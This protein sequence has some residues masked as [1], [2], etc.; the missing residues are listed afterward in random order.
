VDLVV[1]SVSSKFIWSEAP[2]SRSQE[3]R[4]PSPEE[5]AKLEPMLPYWRLFPHLGTWPEESWKD[6]GH[7]NH[8]AHACICTHR[9]SLFLCLQFI[10]PVRIAIFFF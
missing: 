5:V 10:P 7:Y 9:V 3:L 8:L 4:S 6:M 2:E 1:K